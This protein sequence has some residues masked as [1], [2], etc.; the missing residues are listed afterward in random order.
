MCVCLCEVSVEER[1]SLELDILALLLAYLL[2]VSEMKHKFMQE[3]SA[4]IQLHHFQAFGGCLYPICRTLCTAQHCILLMVPAG[5][6]HHKAIKEPAF[7]CPS[8][9][10]FS[11][12]LPFPG[13]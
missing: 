3:T 9:G 11:C 2:A 1:I 5:Q 13:G 12:L 6:C 4:K 10:S 8:S 7:L